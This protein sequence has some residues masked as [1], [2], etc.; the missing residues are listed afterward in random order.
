VNKE[1]ERENRTKTETLRSRWE[2]QFVLNGNEIYLVPPIHR[3]KSTYNYRHLR[4][5][6]KNSGNVI[7][8]N[9]MT[10]IREIIGV[11]QIK[12]EMIKLDNPLGEIVYQLVAGND[13]IYD[14]KNRMYRSFIVF[15]EQGQ[16]LL[17]NKDYEGTAIFCTKSK[18]GKLHLFSNEQMY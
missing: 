7:Y 10:D 1:K 15:D 8:D 4:V 16:E 18:I 11:Y 17:N 9:Y 3:V 13:V 2:P 6:V 14:S 5:V 12:N